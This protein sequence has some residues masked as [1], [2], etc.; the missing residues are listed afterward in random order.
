MKRADLKYLSVLAN[1]YPNIAS[2]A[3]EIVN[4]KAI[5][6]LP[7]GT[8]HFITDV[9]GESE[10]VRHVMNGGSGSRFRTRST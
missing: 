10:Q 8:E 4:L 1:Q 2:V 3:T 9:H 6:S 7:K 5:M